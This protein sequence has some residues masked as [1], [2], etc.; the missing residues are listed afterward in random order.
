MIEELFSQKT[1]PWS[2]FSVLITDCVAVCD[3]LYVFERAQLHL[4]ATCSSALSS[5]LLGNTQTMI[6]LI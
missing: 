3:F 5:D 1:P 4:N 6:Q 2:R